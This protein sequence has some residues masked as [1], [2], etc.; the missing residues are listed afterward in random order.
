MVYKSLLF[1]K[2]RD[3]TDDEKRIL[4]KM[5]DECPQGHIWSTK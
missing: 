4:E 5:A 2:I 3:E 1:G